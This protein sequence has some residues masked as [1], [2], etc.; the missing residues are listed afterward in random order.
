[1]NVDPTPP[2]G[3]GPFRY[4]RGARGRFT[5]PRDM[6]ILKRHSESMAERVTN[7]L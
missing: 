2:Y 4:A 5:M 3:F 6:L 1:M 7:R